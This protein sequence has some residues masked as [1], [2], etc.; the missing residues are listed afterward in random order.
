MNLTS[1]IDLD[2]SRN[3]IADLRLH[4]FER[5]R[6]LQTL[7]LSSI[8]LERIEHGLFAGQSELRTLDI[9]YNRLM[10]ADHIDWTTISTLH[11]LNELHVNGI[12]L[13]D[14]T[15]LFSIG[16]IKQH[17]ISRL[18]IVDNPLD[19]RHLAGFVE[20][21]GSWGFV[22]PETVAVYNVSNVHGIRCSAD[23]PSWTSPAIVG[24]TARPEVALEDGH[25][26]D[27]QPDL[28]T[29]RIAIDRVASNLVVGFSLVT[30]GFVLVVGV[31]CGFLAMR[32]SNRYHGRQRDPNRGGTVMDLI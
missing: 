17:R 24:Q 7:N 15:G 18:G 1:L 27:H 31:L 3:A 5:M 25:S 19:C 20:E 30:V 26:R 16:L 11:N 23:G 13:H 32:L 10:M 22:I 14:L 9:S 29:L 6:N 12:G 8:G 21:F 2:I 4:S 28:A